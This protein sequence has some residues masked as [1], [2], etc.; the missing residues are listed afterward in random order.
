MPV[1]LMIA[2]AHT[3]TRY[4]LRELAGRHPDIEVT[5]ECGSAADVAARVAEV[6]PDVV[7]LAMNLPDGDGLLLARQLRGQ[8]PGLGIVILTSRAEDTVLFR[9]LEAGA[10]AFVAK[11]APAEEIVAAIRHAA[12]AA[13]SF[14]AS[15]LASALARRQ[16]T[17][18]QFALSQRELE[19]LTLLRDGLSIP[20]IAARLY[21][22]PS[23][24]KTYAARLYD[25]LGAANR[26]QALMAAIHHGLLGPAWEPAPPSA[27]PPARAVPAAPVLAVARAS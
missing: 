4:G 19:V 6:P 22:S 3:L 1:R 8:H 20:A 24:A 13:A 16:A 26:A 9:A 12:V 27:L 7:T 23:T 17:R 21:V 18:D 10:S 15:G 25:K 14:T 11:T 2:D 5:A